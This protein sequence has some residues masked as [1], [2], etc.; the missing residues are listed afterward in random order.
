MRIDPIHLIHKSPFIR[1]YRNID[2][3]VMDFFDYSPFSDYERRVNDLKLRTFQRDEL[4]DVLVRMNKRWGADQATIENI[5]R[6]REEGSVVV[7]GGQQAGLLTGPLYTFNKIISILHFSKKQEEKLGIPV[8]P[9]F[10]IAGEDHDFDEIN[11]IYMQTKEAIIKHR[12]SQFIPGKFPISNISLE[13]DLIKK[14]LQQIFQE[15]QETMYTKDLYTTIRRVLEQSDT[16]VD[17]FAKLINQF[18]ANYGLVLIDS[19]DQ[20]LRKLER[21]YFKKMILHQEKIAKSVYDR[22]QTLASK[23]YIIDLDAKIN[24]AHLFYHLHNERVL[25][26]RTKDGKWIGKQE[27]V[28]FTT[29]ELLQKLEEKPY[30]FSNNVV[31]RP[32]MQ[33]L[34]FPTLAFVAGDGEISYWGVLKDA[35]HQ[36]KLKMPPVLPRLSFT[37]VDLQTE[38]L[39]NKYS[40]SLKDAINAGLEIYKMNWL[41]QKQQPPIGQLIESIKESIDSVHRSLRDVARSIRADLEGLANKNLRLIHREL[42]Y[43]EQRLQNALEEKYEKEIGHF[44]Q[45][46]NRLY[47]ENSLQE[48]VLNPIHLLNDYG[49]TFIDQMLQ[50]NFSYEKDHYVIYL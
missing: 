7:I 23:D 16:Y 35:F 20:D 21:E 1:K 3:E 46:Q 11:H 32:L 17:F 15:M 28:L 4:A 19:A 9:V 33:E 50:L 10:W 22:L 8:I 48:R 27:E 41:K 6:L 25:L 29:D 39:L 2:E 13:H 18:F 24:D 26:E 36:L 14:W 42:D 30:L 45:L 5:E 12:V 38:Q 31:T 49:Y 43:V 47:P 44:N 40:I 34:L 37:Y